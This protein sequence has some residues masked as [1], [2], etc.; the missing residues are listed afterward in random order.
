[1]FTIKK[2]LLSTVSA[3]ALSALIFSPSTLLAADVGAEAASSSSA[4]AKSSPNKK[5]TTEEA[6]ARGRPYA[7][8]FKLVNLDRG[9]LWGPANPAAAQQLLEDASS[10]NVRGMRTLK[11]IAMHE[12]WFNFPPN[13]QAAREENDRLYREFK[14]E[15]AASCMMSG[16]ACGGYGY[17]ANHD[18]LRRLNEELKAA[19]SG[20]SIANVDETLRTL[21]DLMSHGANPF[22]D[23][24]K[25]WARHFLRAQKAPENSTETNDGGGEI[26]RHMELQWPTP[27]SAITLA[28]Q[29]AAAGASPAAAAP[30]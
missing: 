7:T 25:T 13:P 30:K 15:E 18:E 14:D 23:S 28:P 22:R 27:K 24:I 19:G 1:M 8:L 10:C 16:L 5:K 4:A 26:V 6:V 12:G 29:Q 21:A 17:K 20:R 11:V 2:T 9:G 3:L